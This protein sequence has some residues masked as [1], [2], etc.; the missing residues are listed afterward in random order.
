M[1]T[2]S[3]YEQLTK[4]PLFSTTKKSRRQVSLPLVTLIVFSFFTAILFL[5]CGTPL[6]AKEKTS[7]RIV[8]EVNVVNAVT[9]VRVYKDGTPVAGLKKDDFKLFL[10]G[11]QIPINGFFEEIK[12]INGSRTEG[13]IVRPTGKPKPR[14][15][16]LV[17][18]VGQFNKELLAT[19]D[20]L[21]DDVL[22]PGDYVMLFS[23]NFSLN[24]R[25]I[26]NTDLEKKKLK[27]LLKIDA[28]SLS[29]E[30]QLAGEQISANYDDLMTI[31]EFSDNEGIKGHVKSFCTRYMHIFRDFKARYANVA[32]GQS[33]KLA[34]YLKRVDMDKWVI[35]IYQLDVFP[36]IK[37][38]FNRMFR[39][40]ASQYPLLR[41]EFN[42]MSSALKTA[43]VGA[44]RKMAKYF[45]DT[46]ATF[47]TLMLGSQ[48]K[49]H[50]GAFASEAI[51]T[52][53]ETGM[54][55]I[56]ESTGGLTLHSGSAKA[57]AQRI[58]E[59]KDVSYILSYIPTTKKKKVKIKILTSE[60]NHRIVY[61]NKIK[62]V[63][64][65]SKIKTAS[66]KSQV[67]IKDISFQK[68]I[69][70]IMVSGV[71]M[72]LVDNRKMG[73]IL[74]AIKIMDRTGEVSNVRKAFNCKQGT[75]NLRLKPPHLDKG[76]YMVFVEI[77]DVLT[78]KNDIRTEDIEVKI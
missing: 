48:S 38:L 60:K 28:L 57:F 74:L 16:V 73:K 23:N 59:H 14:L 58:S 64:P 51:A 6:S 5:N 1:L 18:N 4:L 37:P 71:K 26:K 61:N 75:L 66:I 20:S 44:A 68:K 29:R 78:G 27:A 39:Y 8:E 77:S 65:L 76:K 67:T 49:T 31:L 21:Y 3:V 70:S 72:G 34:D 56:A 9:T 46:G 35:N 41:M 25:L 13:A 43:D 7:E 53:A 47:H 52:E 15:F 42:T 54:K 10:E 36:Q 19:I 17:F 55:E 45:I 33:K 69:L 22:R 2:A 32:Q 30:L 40:L 62:H 11:K 50:T 63:A 24:T 12:Q